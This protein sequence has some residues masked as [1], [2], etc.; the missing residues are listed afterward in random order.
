MAI[1][2]LTNPP[3]EPVTLE[4][5]KLHC[6][7][8]VDDDDTI[9]NGLIATARE[10]C[11][12]FSGRA[13]VQRS[14]MLTMTHWPS[15]RQIILPRPPL[16]SVASVVYIDADG[17]PQTLTAGTDYLVDLMHRW[18][19]IVLPVAAQ[20]PME[21]MQPGTPIRITYTAGYET[22]PGPPINYTANVPEYVKTAMKLCIGNW[23]ENRENVLPA[24]HVGK[25]LPQG[26]ECMLWA[27]R[28]DWSEVWNE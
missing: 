4:E 13:Y 14:L 16:A 19:R 21:A 9:I 15:T 22:L 3:V 2:Q 27:E 17:N 8:D 23:Y 12:T 24:G 1:R 7:I 20:W 6:R 10:Y 26:A 5:A 28:M 11:E 25:V 18:G